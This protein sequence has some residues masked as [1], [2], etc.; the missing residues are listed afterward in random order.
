MTTDAAIKL[1]AAKNSLV[2]SLFELS[3]ASNQTA[4]SIVDFY[5][6]I[7]EDEDE[8]L[9]AFTTLTEALQ[10][11]TSATNS[12]NGI[13]SELVNPGEDEKDV[14]AATPVKAPAKKKVERDPN[15]PKK[16]LTVF[17]AYSAYVRQELRDARQRA[18]L[19]PLSS[20]EITQEIS[21]KWKDLSDAEK[22]TWKKAYNVELEH[23]QK[24]KQEYLEAKK[25]GTLPPATAGP[26]HAPVPI[27]FGLIQHE[28][29][30]PHDD[31]SSEKKKKKKKK[32]KKKDKA[33]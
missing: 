27:P 22:D 12:L 26:K 5:N 18:G 3:K 25:N 14:S 20:T 24:A 16:P 6:N 28:N 11:L 29:K 13:S 33:A 21:K 4:S 23:Y 1:K 9:E 2:A 10:N 8:K 30:R 7:G 31:D 15:A 19:A 17:F 32:D